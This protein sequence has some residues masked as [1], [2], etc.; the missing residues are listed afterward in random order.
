MAQDD[1]LTAEEQRLLKVVN[2]GIEQVVIPALDSLEKE[3][4]GEIKEV[5]DKLNRVE[6]RLDQ[7]DRKLDNV[8][9]MSFEH[10]HQIETLKSLPT[11]AHEL[12]LK[13]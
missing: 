10:K 2:L 9:A 11:I 6:N 4:K 5:K 7:I 13:N 12:K 3:L 1:N 8:T